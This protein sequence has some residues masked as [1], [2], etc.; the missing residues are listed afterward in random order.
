MITVGLTGGIASGKSL[1]TS[2]LRELAVPVIDTDEI[3][4]QVVAVGQPAWR[5]LREEFGDAYFL[6][7]GQLDRVALARHVFTDPAARLRLEAITHPAIFAEVEHGLNAYRR[8]SAP[9]VVVVVPLLFE[10]HAE[11]RFAR[12]AVVYATPPQ[13]RTRLIEL[14]GYT[15]EEAD[16]RMAAQLP[17]DEKAC[18]ADI[19]ID[20]SGTIEQTR[21]Q[22][23]E[24]LV[25]CGL[26]VGGD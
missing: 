13:Q 5:R 10:V 6:P 24:H 21:R 11:D 2:L 26:K 8:S 18:R 16:A 3:S 17:I 25:D 22:V 9:L 12:I 20:N 7:D 4:R 15:P 19:L 23:R 14:R 1:V